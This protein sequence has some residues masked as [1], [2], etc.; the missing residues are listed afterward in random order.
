[1]NKILILAIVLASST[2]ARSIPTPRIQAAAVAVEAAP[3]AKAAPA[4]PAAK[5]AA[6]VI[7]TP[8]SKGKIQM[9]LNDDLVTSPHDDYN[10][11]SKKQKIVLG[12]VLGADLPLEGDALRRWESRHNPND[13]ELTKKER[14]AR[15]EPAQEAERQW[16][17]GD[18][19]R[20]EKLANKEGP[21]IEKTASKN[22]PK[23]SKK[24]L[25]NKK[26]SRMSYGRKLND[27]DEIPGDGIGP[28][29]YVGSKPNDVAPRYE[30]SGVSSRPLVGSYSPTPP[31]GVPPAQFDI[32]R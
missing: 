14:V 32:I 9:K 17:K 18:L 26:N 22:K 12:A 15:S 20:D 27:N 29:P 1:M 11:L 13:V 28:G 8:V 2:S 24:T 19:S 31:G 7:D 10:E 23:L 3:E 30:G 25:S 5:K 6:E 4:A 21:E 16:R